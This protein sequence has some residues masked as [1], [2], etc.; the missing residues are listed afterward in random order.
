MRP[1]SCVT[2]PFAGDRIAVLV[3]GPRVFPTALR[4]AGSTLGLTRRITSGRFDGWDA[5]TQSRG[6]LAGCAAADRVPD[7]F[8]RVAAR[9]T[10]PVVGLE[11]FDAVALTAGRPAEADAGLLAIAVEIAEA[12]VAGEA[13]AADR[14][15]GAL[16]A[17][18]S[19]L[20]R[21]AGGHRRGRVVFGGDAVVARARVG[22]G[23]GRRGAVVAR[24]GR[25][26]RDAEP[27]E[28]RQ[29]SEALACVALARIGTGRAVFAGVGVARD[30]RGATEQ[31][32]EQE[33]ASER[34]TRH[35]PSIAWVPTR[36]QCDDPPGLE[37]RPRG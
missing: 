32:A 21:V 15:V 6:T 35:A 11:I 16:T 17:G 1:A 3:P 25:G 12:L 20:T 22:S 30:R 33:A 7:C 10:V 9:P 24:A 37:A 26:V 36:R 31:H 23:R 34:T 13:R 5:H 4:D 18:W 14:A 27:G 28:A 19:A 29:P 8:A 2:M